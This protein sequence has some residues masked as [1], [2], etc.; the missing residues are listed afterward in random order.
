MSE[1][2]NR[3]EQRVGSPKDIRYSKEVK[4]RVTADQK[5][6]VQSLAKQFGK[7]ESDVL[8]FALD[9]V[10]GTFPKNYFPTKKE[11]EAM[12]E[13]LLVMINL[14]NDL[15]RIGKKA[16]NN[17]NQIARAINSGK[18]DDICNGDFYIMIE[19]NRELMDQL[20]EVYARLE[21]HLKYRYD[22]R[23]SWL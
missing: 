14:L 18:I 23:S 11:V 3:D 6:Y 13:Y 15:N 2:K 8:R 21:P 22:R 20:R 1:K 7:P 5:E 19:E 4:A 17:E 9:V 12:R 10:N 16:G